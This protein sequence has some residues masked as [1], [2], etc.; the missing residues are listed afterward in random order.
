MNKQHGI[1]VLT[2]GG[3]IDKYYFD[4]HSQYQLVE[5]RCP[6]FRDL[7]AQADCPLPDYVQEIQHR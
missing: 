3:A 4:A 6:A 2:T 5:R 7:Q 1:T